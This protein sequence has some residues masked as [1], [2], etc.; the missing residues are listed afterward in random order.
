VGVMHWGHPLQ[1]LYQRGL[2]WTA[3]AAAT[4]IHGCANGRR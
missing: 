4:C 1:L 3:M 2:F